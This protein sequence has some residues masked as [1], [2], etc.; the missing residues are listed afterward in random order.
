MEKRGNETGRLC[1]H[2]G[3]LVG[4]HKRLFMLLFIRLWSN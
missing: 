1:L 3:L 4:K 2:F